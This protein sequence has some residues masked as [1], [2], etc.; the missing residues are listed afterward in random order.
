MKQSQRTYIP[1]AGH[2]WFLPLYDVMTKLMGADR[3]RTALLDQPGLESC[4]RVLDVGCGTGSLAILLKQR[5]PRME[6]IGLDPDPKALARARRKAQQARVAPWFEQGF[7]DTLAHSAESFD[8]VFSSFMF[9]HL[10]HVQKEEMLR[11]ICRVLKPG[12][13]LHLL[14]FSDPESSGSSLSRWLHS[15]HHLKDNSERRILTLMNTAG[16]ADVKVVG[17]RTALFGLLH[18]A[19]FEAAAPATL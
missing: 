17:H 19:Y 14:D 12:G 1:A 3:A 4:Q 9:H 6:V 15:H 5:Y 16:L 13:R 11:E 2:D 7:S 10:D 18:V 8:R